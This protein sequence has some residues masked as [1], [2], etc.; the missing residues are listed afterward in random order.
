MQSEQVVLDFFARN[1]RA[2]LPQSDVLELRYLDTG[3]IDS[4]GIITLISE[5]EG[6]LGIQFS[7][8][9]LQSPEF[10]TIGGLIGIVDRLRNK[11]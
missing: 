3:M 10:Q 1:G 11:S 7:A 9:D 6:K 8:A 5:L 2:P 4:L